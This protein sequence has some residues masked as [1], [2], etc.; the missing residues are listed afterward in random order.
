MP[1]KTLRNYNRLFRSYI[2]DQLRKSQ[3]QSRRIQNNLI[4]STNSLKRA[5]NK[6]EKHIRNEL[7]ENGKRHFNTQRTKR[8]YQKLKRLEVLKK[9]QGRKGSVI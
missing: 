2:K 5:A 7:N 4:P 8:I 9:I 1:E 6:I 3:G